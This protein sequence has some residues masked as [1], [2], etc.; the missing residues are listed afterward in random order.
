MPRVS[1]NETL[2]VFILRIDLIGEIVYNNTI[3]L[4]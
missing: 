3:A 1:K 4:N 2:G